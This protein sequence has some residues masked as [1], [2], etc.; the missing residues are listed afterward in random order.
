M[1]PESITQT[2]NIMALMSVLCYLGWA[3]K[4]HSKNVFMVIQ[5]LMVLSFIY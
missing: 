4:K 2:S 3:I 1:K 5:T